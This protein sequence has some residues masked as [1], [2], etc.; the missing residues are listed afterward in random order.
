VAAR[1]RWRCPIRAL[2]SVQLGRL[3][4]RGSELWIKSL[5]EPG[6]SQF[7][8]VPLP[9]VSLVGPEVRRYRYPMSAMQFTASLVASLVWPAAVVG[10]L[11][12]AWHNRIQI[13]QFINSYSLGQ[14]RRLQRIK[15]GPIELEWEQLVVAAISAT[16]DI[17]PL[18]DRLDANAK[19]RLERDPVRAILQEFE[20]I[21]TDLGIRVKDAKPKLDLK[22]ID[23][24][25]LRTMALALGIISPQTFS[26]LGSLVKLRNEAAH[27]VGES[28]ITAVHA[29]QYF[30]L[31]RRVESALLLDGIEYRK[32]SQ[33]NP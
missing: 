21:E 1:S 16:A 10:M 2:Y 26:A 17:N 3:G 33:P 29:R 28:D 8:Q 22:G 14:G 6:S 25:Q 27:R 18:P 13:T 30:Q 31:V 15:A 7:A 24:E 12:L 19:M 23:F 32:R 20:N 9:G 11:F 4:W 5:T